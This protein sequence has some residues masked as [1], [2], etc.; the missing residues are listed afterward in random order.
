MIVEASSSKG[1][2]ATQV[3]QRIEERRRREEE[4]EGSVAEATGQVED[5]AH[6]LLAAERLFCKRSKYT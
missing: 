2:L 4:A 6:N 3:R 1:L 5:R